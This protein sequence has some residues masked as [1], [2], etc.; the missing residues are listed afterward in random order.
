MNRKPSYWRHLLSAADTHYSMQGVAELGAVALILCAVFYFAVIPSARVALERT[1]FSEAL[2][3]ISAQRIDITIERAQTGE[4]PESRM[5]VR[6]D[7]PTDTSG[8]YVSS[9]GWSNGVIEVALHHDD[10]KDN[11][12]QAGRL[13]FR[14]AINTANPSAPLVWICG[15]WR[16]PGPFEPLA[17]PTTELEPKQLPHVCRDLSRTLNL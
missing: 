9:V 11:P 5:A 10:D 3:L 17:G 13:Y 6:G 15:E 4:W 2:T 7:E 1:K 8:K 12:T 14:P 16:P